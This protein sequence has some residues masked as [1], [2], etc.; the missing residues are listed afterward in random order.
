MSKVQS[1]LDGHAYFLSDCAKC[2]KGIFSSRFP[3][4]NRH[5]KAGLLYQN[6]VRI[7][8]R[9]TNANTSEPSVVFFFHRLSTYF[10]TRATSSKLIFREKKHTT[11]N[12]SLTPTIT[13][14]H[15]FIVLSKFQ[16]LPW[17]LSTY[18]SHRT[19]S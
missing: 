8:Y 6:L 16:A 13:I 18:K 12:F 15:T 14:S 4:H 3:V 10:K 1:E 17:V 11:N 2:R 9:L 5:C 7:Y 19:M